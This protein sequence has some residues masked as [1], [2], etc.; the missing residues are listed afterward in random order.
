MLKQ[1]LASPEAAMILE[2]AGITMKKFGSNCSELRRLVGVTSG[3]TGAIAGP[4][5][6]AKVLEMTWDPEGPCSAISAI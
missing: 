6:I 3:E 1:E 2:A 4:D 5:G